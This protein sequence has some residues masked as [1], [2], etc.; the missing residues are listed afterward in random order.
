MELVNR[1][2]AAVIRRE[3]ARTLAGLV[4]IPIASVAFG[5]VTAFYDF[6]RNL[7]LEVAAAV[8]FAVLVFYLALAVLFVREGRLTLRL[9][10]FWRMYPAAVKIEGTAAT[11]RYRDGSEDMVQISWFLRMRPHPLEDDV[12]LIDWTGADGRRKSVRVGKEI[13]TRLQEARRLSE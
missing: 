10:G 7:T 6:E 8:V 5:L 11:F 4:V 12:W 3:K 2:D 1:V 9:R 13:A